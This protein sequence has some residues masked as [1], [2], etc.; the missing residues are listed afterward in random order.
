MVRLKGRSAP[1]CEPPPEF[2]FLMVRLKVANRAGANLI[3]LISIPYG[4]IKRMLSLSYSTSLNIFQFLMVRLKG[5]GIKKITH[6]FCIS[7]P[8]GSIKSILSYAK[9][10]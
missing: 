6:G 8:Y 7:I 3:T 5:I 2:Q 1:A 10:R 4:S 9:P